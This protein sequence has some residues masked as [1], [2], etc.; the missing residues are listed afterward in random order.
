MKD[1]V[2]FFAYCVIVTV[3]SLIILKNINITIN[4]NHTISAKNDGIHFKHDFNIKSGYAESIKI[5]I[6]K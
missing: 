6:E 5:R 3:F 2:R 1:I 4:H